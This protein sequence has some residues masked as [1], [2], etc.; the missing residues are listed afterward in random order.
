MGRRHAAMRVLCRWVRSSMRI[1]GIRRQG[2]MPGI[3]RTHHLPSAI[4]LLHLIAQSHAL[5]G[6]DALRREDHRGI[7]LIAIE[8]HGRNIDV[9]RCDIQIPARKMVQ[10]ALPDRFFALIAAVTRSQA[11]EEHQDGS[12]SHT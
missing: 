1:G 6:I 10:H 5:A 11:G 7:G 3:L 8:L 9:H 2:G 4:L 12:Y